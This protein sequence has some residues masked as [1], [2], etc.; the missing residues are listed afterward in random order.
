[1]ANS[2]T[3]RAPIQQVDGT[4]ERCYVAVT[5]LKP[6]AMFSKQVA[7]HPAGNAGKDTTRLT[8]SQIYAILSTK[9]K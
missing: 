2:T 8:Q 4:E 3:S 1:M 9:L 5:C 6:K 7:A